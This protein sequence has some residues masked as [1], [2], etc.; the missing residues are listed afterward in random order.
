MK[1]F[2]VTRKQVRRPPSSEPILC[3]KCHEKTKNKV[4]TTKLGFGSKARKHEYRCVV[5]DSVKLT[6]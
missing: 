6:I 5:C 2:S 3:P 1:R 4:V